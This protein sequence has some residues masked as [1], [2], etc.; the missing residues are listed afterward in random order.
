MSV[1]STASTRYL[2]TLAE[3]S[4]V[5]TLSSGV[6]SFAVNWKARS[7]GED[8]TST[9]EELLAAAHASCFAMA[10]THGLT[11]AGTPPESVDT[12]A[13]VTFQAGEGI[14]GIELNV[15]ARVP[16]LDANGFAAAAADAKAGC[17]V[18]QALAG[19]EITLGTAVLAE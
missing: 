18:S 15:E 14:T 17:P 4:G 11:E 1:T 8:A 5:T 6:G 7:E 12:S 2:G 16:G 9:P 3:G 10:L 19:V 13:R